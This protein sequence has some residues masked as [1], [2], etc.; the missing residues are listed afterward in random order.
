MN[1]FHKQMED[2]PYESE[3]FTYNPYEMLKTEDGLVE[4]TNASLY[5][6]VKAIWYETASRLDIFSARLITFSEDTNKLLFE[7]LYRMG[8]LSDVEYP[9]LLNGDLITVKKTSSISDDEFV[10]KLRAMPQF[11]YLKVHQMR[12]GTEID[13][14]SMTNVHLKNAIRSIIMHQVFDESMGFKRFNRVELHQYYSSFFSY[15]FM[16]MN[17]HIVS[18]IAFHLPEWENI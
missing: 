18:G 17:S 10:N 3:G 1:T 5:Q 9:L 2:F 4:L 6:K 11:S 16:K 15:D 13:V 8:R 12:N 14:A 7:W